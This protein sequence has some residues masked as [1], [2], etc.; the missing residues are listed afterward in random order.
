MRLYR[1]R[2]MVMTPAEQHDMVRTTVV[3]ASLFDRR[4]IPAGMEA[5]VL[6]ASPDGPAWLSLRSRRKPQ[7]KT[8]ISSKPCSPK[9]STKS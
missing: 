6:E 1:R 8:V 5:T 3:V 4:S 2:E 7:S 9:A